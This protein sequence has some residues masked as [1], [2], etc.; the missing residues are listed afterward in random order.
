[1]ITPKKKNPLAV[2]LGT[3]AKGKTS[4]RKA[5]SSAQN[6]KKGGRPKKLKKLV[7]NLSA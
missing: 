6:G 3:M 5:M 2:A 7:D 1:M 4:P